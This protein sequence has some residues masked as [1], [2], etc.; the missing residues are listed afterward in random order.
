MTISFS[1]K[2]IGHLLEAV[3]DSD[4]WMRVSPQVFESFVRPGG[5][6]YALIRGPINRE[7]VKID[8]SGSVNEMLKVER[9]QGGTSAFAWPLGNLLFN[10][11]N[12][13][14]YNAII[15]LEESRVIGY[16]PN[17]IL[18]PL[19]A[20]EKIYQDSPAGCE[21]WWTSFN[22]TDPYWDIITGAACGDEYYQD[23]GWT[24]D[25]LLAAP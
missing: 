11:T 6:V 10:S 1:H 18:S 24:Y 16:N 22:G 2:A 14:H 8:A 7:V 9:G 5:E 25:L 17:Q 21:R 23:I 3:T 15:Q 13:D 20:G 12:E 19:Y 4:V